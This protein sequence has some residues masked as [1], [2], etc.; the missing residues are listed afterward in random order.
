MRLMAYWQTLRGKG[1]HAPVDH[2]DPEAIKDF[3]AYCFVIT[4]AADMGDARFSHIG[5]KLA[6]ESG[7]EAGPMT[8]SEVPADTTLEKATKVVSEVLRV[9][10]PVVDGGE[11]SDAQGRR[12]LYRSIIAPLTDSSGAITLLV[13]AARSTVS[14]PG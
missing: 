5:E 7:I 11:F 8:L 3:W 4:P 13:G 9:N 10:Y 6:A 12:R 1:H 14:T 2:F